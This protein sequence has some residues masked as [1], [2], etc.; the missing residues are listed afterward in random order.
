MSHGRDGGPI[1]EELTEERLAGSEVL[2][3]AELSKRLRQPRGNLRARSHV[4]QLRGERG[5]EGL[6]E[7]IANSVSSR[8]QS[9]AAIAIGIRTAEETVGRWAIVGRRSGPSAAQKGHS[10]AIPCYATS[11]APSTVAV[12]SDCPKR[13]VEASQASRRL[14]ASES[15]TVWSQAVGSVGQAMRAGSFDAGGLQMVRSRLNAGPPQLELPQTNVTT[16]R[17]SPRRLIARYHDQLASSTPVA[18]T[19]AMSLPL[20]RKLLFLF[21]CLVALAPICQASIGDDLP[22]FNDCV[23]ACI[24][25]KCDVASPT[26]LPLH[27]RLL[28]WDCPSECD[29]VC[30]RHITHARIE[31]GDSVEQFHGKWP[32]YRVFGVQEPFSVIFSVMNGLQ[33]YRG[34]HL[35]NKEFHSSYPLRSIFVF[36]A[37]LGMAAWFFSAVFHTRDSIPTERMDYFGAGA[38]V[39]FNLFYAPIVIFRPFNR[40]QLSLSGS[41]RK[42][43]PW[44]YFWGL[45][46]MAAYAG[47]VYFLQFVRWDYTYNMAA[48]VVVGMCQN[49]LWIYYSITRYDRERK[50]WA[51]WP[52]AIVLW[53]AFSMSLELLDFPPLFDALDA[54]ALWHAATILPIMWMYR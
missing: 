16:A 48:N 50:P 9:R 52:A 3:M 10:D 4:A 20:S 41:E 22:E 19:G 33:F 27:L 29:Y 11:R 1:V 14:V 31:K 36:G 21:A 13:H 6:V 47:H 43:A 25:Q 2:R 35:I 26:P 39:L 40:T 32:F 30:Q 54:H 44:V 5:S 51:L 28:W 37:Y 38:L 45:A 23:D 49:V 18:P 12:S 24:R 7:D 42:F 15:Q 34:L 8:Y 46:C 17:P 53:V